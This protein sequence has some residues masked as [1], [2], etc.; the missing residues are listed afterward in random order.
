MCRSSA[1]PISCVNHSICIIPQLF[2]CVCVCVPDVL[3]DL[4]PS[5]SCDLCE[6]VMCP[7]PF[8][9]AFFYPSVRFDLFV[10]P[11]SDYWIF[12][13]PFSDPLCMTHVWTIDSGF[14]DFVSAPSLFWIPGNKLYS[15]TTT[16]LWIAL[17][18]PVC[19]DYDPLPGLCITNC[20]PCEI[21][22]CWRSTLACL[23]CDSINKASSK[24][25]FLVLLVP[26]T[27]IPNNFTQN[28]L[29]SKL[30]SLSS[31]EI[32]TQMR[33]SLEV[34]YYLKKFSILM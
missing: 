27:L 11:D 24:E 3:L 14:L 5:L 10:H 9:Q 20:L 22:V 6:I 15:V 17:V 19:S 23:L 12:P 34:F 33:D 30:F 16:T 13:E 2:F 26:Q 21:T 4:N 31:S 25:L 1:I 18:I 7:V 32:F 29:Y 28:A 8:L